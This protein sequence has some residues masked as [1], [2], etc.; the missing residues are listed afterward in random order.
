MRAGRVVI[1][2]KPRNGVGVRTLVFGPCP[3]NS[4]SF[5]GYVFTMEKLVRISSATYGRHI[6]LGRLYMHCA[7]ISPPNLISVI[8]LSEYLSVE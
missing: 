2:G 5:C 8:P 3:V 4:P 7:N 1:L 6:N